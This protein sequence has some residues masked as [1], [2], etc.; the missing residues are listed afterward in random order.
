MQNMSIAID[1]LH[2][3][4]MEL[5]DEAFYAKK[6]QDD[7]S[8]QAKYL[9]AFE[10]EKAA[11]ML[12]VNEY[13][14]EPSRSVLFRSAACLLL[15]LPIPTDKHFRQAERMVAYGLSGNPPEEIAEELREVWRELMG[16]LQKEA[17]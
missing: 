3:K 10:Y 8:A 15:N 14:Q 16:H 2:Q 4:A 17:A 6:K 5:A 7:K 12:L 9:A 1:E 13:D 11:A